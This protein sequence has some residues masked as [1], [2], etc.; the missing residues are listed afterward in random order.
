MVYKEDA[1]IEVPELRTFFREG[2]TYLCGRN[3]IRASA[4]GE[5]GIISLQEAHYFADCICS[6]RF[7]QNSGLGYGGQKPQILVGDNIFYSLY[8]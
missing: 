7:Q 6:H 1:N 2:M 4:F 3:T 5:N 8:L